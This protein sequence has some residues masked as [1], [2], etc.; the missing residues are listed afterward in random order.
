MTDQGSIRCTVCNTGVP[1]KSGICPKCKKNTHVW[2]DV[3]W[4]LKAG[5][6]GKH[7]P[8]RR[9]ERG[10]PLSFQSAW[11]IRKEV[12][13]DIRRRTFK[14]WKYLPEGRSPRRCELFFDRWLRDVHESLSEGTYRAYRSTVEAHLLPYWG[15]KDIQD[16]VTARALKTWIVELERKRRKTAARAIRN[17]MHAFLLWASSEGLLDDIPTFKKIVGRDERKKYA[18]TLQQQ[19]IYAEKVRHPVM[20]RAIILGMLTGMRMSEVLTLKASDVDFE[21]RSINV[22]RTWS[23]YKIKPTTKTSEPRKIPLPALAFPI[24]KE[25]IGK[26]VGDVW[27]FPRADGTLPLHGRQFTRYWKETGCPATIRDATRRSYATVLKDQG[28]PLEKIKELLGHRS[29]KTTEIYLIDEP[30]RMADEVDK[31][32]GKLLRFRNENLDETEINSGG[33]KPDE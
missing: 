2:I 6:D 30:M 20:R 4:S 11:N 5:G 17:R 10:D 33:S 31:L 1:E 8:I 13:A 16:G 22:R 27:L 12:Q 32:Q 28:F 25:A 9:D 3:Y 21:E 15:P 7:Y 18:L 14:P 23:G 29:I 26:R 24:V 19:F